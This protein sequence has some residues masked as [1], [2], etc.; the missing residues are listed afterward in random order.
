MQL[1][2]LIDSDKAE[3]Y[4]PTIWI[5]GIIVATSPGFAID[6]TLGGGRKKQYC[7]RGYDVMRWTRL[8]NH[9]KQLPL[10]YLLGIW[11]SLSRH[12]EVT[13]ALACISRF[14]SAD[15]VSGHNWLAHCIRYKKHGR[16]HALG[17]V[18]PPVIKCFSPLPWVLI[19]SIQIDSEY[20]H[21]CQSRYQP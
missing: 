6:S 18:S 11:S 12:G 7:E 2:L 14:L 16:P 4:S 3:L 10:P 13:S 20:K 19:Y 21:S 8:W 1:S 9:P 5:L 17:R 15:I